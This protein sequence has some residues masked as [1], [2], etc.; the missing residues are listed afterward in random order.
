MAND[1]TT[2]ASQP[3]TLMIDHTSIPGHQNC[4]WQPNYSANLS[5]KPYL[6]SS[7]A[8]SGAHTLL[9]YNPTRLLK[10][11]GATATHAVTT[12]LRMLADHDDVRGYLYP[13]ESIP[14]VAGAYGNWNTGFNYCNVFAANDVVMTIRKHVISP[15]LAHH[16]DIRYV[17]LIGSDEQ[18]PL[19]REWDRAAIANERTFAT[20]TG[21]GPSATSVATTRGF[22][23]TDDAY[24]TPTGAELGWHGR[25]FWRPLLATGRLVETPDEI[26]GTVNRFLSD[27]T[28]TLQPQDALVTG[29]DF[30]SDA[31]EQISDTLSALTV[32]EMIDDAWTADALVNA[33]P[34]RGGDAPDLA[35]INAHF[36][37]WRLQ[38]ADTSDTFY[39]TD[40]LSATASLSGTVA[41]SMGCHAG[42]NV[43][44]AD[45][46]DGQTTPDFPQALAQKGAVWIANTGYGYGTDDGIAGS[47]RLMTLFTQA[48][49]EADPMSIGEALRLAKVRYLHS[50]PAGG[51]TPYDAKSIMEATFYGLPMYQIDMPGLPNAHT[52]TPLQPLTDPQTFSYTRHLLTP[53]LTLR[54]GNHGDYYE[55]AG[56]YGSAH[57]TVGR[58]ILPS[59]SYPL[60]NTATST[61]HGVLI[62]SATLS[63]R[64][65]FDPVVTRPVTDTRLPEPALNPDIGWMPARPFVINN[66]G[67]TPR[68]AATFALFNARTNELRLIDEAAISVLRAPKNRSDYT[69][70]HIS[71][72]SATIDNRGIHITARVSDN[73]SEVEH[74]YATFVSSTRIWTVPLARDSN[75]L[76]GEFWT[77]NAPYAGLNV[78]Y[79]IQAIDEAGNVG[80]AAAKGDYLE[81]EPR[82]LY[83]PL[84]FRLWSDDA[85]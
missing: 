75:D 39:N 60:P 40:I 35:S 81:I 61:P 82:R 32:H 19:Y 74:V 45:V 44:D 20:K 13:I 43:P 58:P 69:A 2:Y 48:L 83:L 34:N 3:Y 68:L 7:A 80:I 62:I 50:L 79:F 26:Q 18:I 1:D 12:T 25:Y 72:S 29:Y 27:P 16:P 4:E 71:A 64:W 9:L 37:H 76:T 36:E 28:H 30:L 65:P 42:Y 67:E 10:T 23:M 52:D 77:G 5:P 55:V 51:L 53:V 15:T 8:I 17:T 73:E 56:P 46:L 59:A 78:S 85:R 6:G 24:G 54:E 66:A 22:Y 70:P 14:E 49:D 21:S 47:E 57:G 84:V 41:W 63:T 33:W 11:Y 31:A 38:P